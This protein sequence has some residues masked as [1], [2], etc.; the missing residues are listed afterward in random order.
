MFFLVVKKTQLRP[1]RSH[2]T[3]SLDST[4]DLQSRWTGTRLWRHVTCSTV[5]EG[6]RQVTNSWYPVFDCWI[7][8]LH[9][10][11]ETNKTGSFIFIE[12]KHRSSKLNLLKRLSRLKETFWSSVPLDLEGK[13]WSLLTGPDSPLKGRSP[14]TREVQ[15]QGDGRKHK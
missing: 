9:R 10:M 1:W 12:V 6:V 7:A 15:C 14:C 3:E 11:S 13:D 8:G 2:V 4:S 5:S